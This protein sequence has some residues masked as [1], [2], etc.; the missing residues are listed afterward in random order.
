ME[1]PML[2]EL[3]DA[4]K[5][6]IAALPEPVK[7]KVVDTLVGKELDKRASLI[8]DGLAKLTQLGNELNR[9]KPD[10]VAYGEDGKPVNSTYSKA[11]IDKRTKLAQQKAKLEKALE[12]ALAGTNFQNLEKL[13]KLKPGEDTGDKGDKGDE[14]DG[15]A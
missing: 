4:I 9:I 5:T 2:T 13:A 8:I 10:Q 3:Q 12:E 7:A 15:D 6:G 11:Q 1:I 14:K